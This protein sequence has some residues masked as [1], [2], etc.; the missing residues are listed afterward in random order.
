MLGCQAGGDNIS[1]I[2]TSTVDLVRAS[3][4][5]YDISMVGRNRAYIRQIIRLGPG[6]A[7]SLV[8]DAG[9]ETKRIYDNTTTPI[10]TSLQ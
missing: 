2:P 7:R 9:Q 5:T 10:T 6:S 8:A 4:D 3:T 1:R